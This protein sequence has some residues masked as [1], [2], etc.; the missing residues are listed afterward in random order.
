MNICQVLISNGWGGTET[1]VYELARHLRDK[2]EKVSII[3]N[4][5]MVKYYADLENVKVFNIGSLYPPKSVIPGIG[6]G[7]QKRD[8]PHRF[9]RLVYSYL[10]ELLRY[11]HYKRLKGDV[12]QFLLDNH[13]DVVHSHLA[14]AAL[15]VS[16]LNGLKTPTINTVHG[17]HT[18]RGITPVH[19][20]ES[21]L[22]KWKARKFKQALARMDRVTEVSNFMVSA[23][24]E[25]GV[26]LKN[27]SAVIYNG[28]NL[29]EIEN[30]SALTTDL[31][32][33][34]NLLFPG[35]PKW[36]KGGDLLIAALAKVKQE[37]PDVHLYIALNVPQNHVLRQTVSNLGL[38]PNVTFTGFLPKEEYRN[39]LNSVDMLV[40]PSR[41]EAF[42][43]VFVEAMALGK[44]IVATNTGGIPEVVQD[45]RNGVLVEPDSEQIAKAILYLYQHADIRKEMSRNSLQDVARFDWNLITDQ[46]IKLYGEMLKE[47]R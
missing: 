9:L 32:G 2:G 44:P 28:I 47:V 19:P 39:L 13:I 17:E 4:Q 45:G 7:S 10:D 15:L 27:K 43:L 37:I 34:F 8:L 24:E 20:L 23:L 16:T 22:I 35:G 42:G 1:V 29:S 6:R 26:N 18:L 33:E 30:S 40:M 46:Y 3:L 36:T 41:E 14:N 5:E 12:R 31:E 21:P 38:E 25:W 11:Q